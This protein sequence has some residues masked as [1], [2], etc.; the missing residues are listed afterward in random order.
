MSERDLIDGRGHVD[1]VRDG[2]APQPILL[3]VGGWNALFVYQPL[4][5]VLPSGVGV[6]VVGL[7]PSADDPFSPVLDDIAGSAAFV[8][9]SG[10]VTAV[11]GDHRP[12]VL[13]GYSRAGLI[14]YE[15]ASRLDPETSAVGLRVMVDTIY[16]GEETRR[17]ELVAAA[18]RVKYRR[19]IES[20]A[21]ATVARQITASAL[22][23]ARRVALRVG[24][25]IMRLAGDRP[26]EIRLPGEV[27]SLTEDDYSPPHTD[28]PVLLY[29]AS[30]S[31]EAR[32]THRWQ[33]V[34]VDL[35]E[36]VIEG[37]HGGDASILGDD[38]VDE[39]AADLSRRLAGLGAP[40]VD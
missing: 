8:I 37:R 32:T 4:V 7:T 25:A 2:D 38:R 18:R 24:T 14:A 27:R 21:Y 34:A 39:M 20:R 36:V 28:F 23:R 17:P 30:T 5:D 9:D 22:A 3:L 29:R 11:T 40:S 10:A 35:T 26:S 33:E 12:L 31:E 1:V 19:L 13:L 15:V 16:P 6:V